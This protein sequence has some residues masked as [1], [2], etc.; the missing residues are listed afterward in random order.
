MSGGL[1][2]GLRAQGRDVRHVVRL[3]DV[4]P[5]PHGRDMETRRA[6]RRSIP[7]G[8]LILDGFIVGSLEDIRPARP[9]PVVAMVHHPLA[10]ESGLDDARAGALYRTE[11]DNLALAPMSS[12]RARTRRNAAT[13]YGVR[14]S[15]SP[16]PVPGTDRP[17]A[18]RARRSPADPVGRY[19]ASAQGARHSSAALAGFAGVS[20]RRSSWARDTTRA[21]PARSTG[22]T[23]IWARRAGAHGGEGVRR[24]PRRALSRGF[25]LRAGHALRGLR[26]RLR[27][28]AEARAA[29]RVLPHRGSPQTVPSAA[30]LLVSPNDAEGFADALAALLQDDRLHARC[31]E[32]ARAAGRVLPKWTDTAR[33]AGDVLDRIASGPH[34]RAT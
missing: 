25:G 27:R 3:G 5:R 24:R 29:D 16:S 23:A 12:C 22:S 34:R 20:G 28:G 17:A 15:V 18:A 7:A 1:L 8:P 9:A 11:R 33:V 30:G 32:A 21:M 19:P 2:E 10:L 31:V 13:R 14:P 6:L 26:H 4:L